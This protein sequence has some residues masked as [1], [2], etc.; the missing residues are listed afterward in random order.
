M[1]E[2]AEQRN[3]AIAL[4]RSDPAEALK[5]ASRIEEAW[6]RA[7]AMASVAR[8]AEPYLAR[9][10]FE[11]SSAAARDGKDSYQRAAVLAWPIR[12]ALETGDETRAEALLAVARRELP[13]IELYCS[14]AEAIDL[15]FQS[16]FYGPQRLWGPLLDDLAALCPPDSHWRS[17][18]VHRSVTAILQGWDG[19]AA[20]KFVE[21]MAG[22]RAQQRCR[23]D[24]DRGTHMLPRPFFWS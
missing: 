17:A 18:R 15:L 23:R 1:S 7:Q 24:L 22:S 10:A 20:R 8:Y 3:T 12:A 19:N 4:S 11:L 9:T 16:A 13:R 21:A 6:F 5:V 2:G 14:R